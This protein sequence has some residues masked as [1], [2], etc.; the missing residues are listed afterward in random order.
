MP[1]CLRLHPYRILWVDDDPSVTGYLS[2]YL[3]RHGYTVEV[4]ATVADAVR[5]VQGESW[6]LLVLDLRLPDGSGLDCLRPL[7]GHPAR[8]PVLVVTGTG[9]TS[10]ALEAG[11]LGVVAYAE[12]PLHGRALLAAV[13]A[14]LDGAPVQVPTAPTPH[15]AHTSRP[16]A[17]TS[18]WPAGPCA[19][20]M[21]A[22]WLTADSLGATRFLVLADGLRGALRMG[23][24]T[25]DVP[26]VTEGTV[27]PRVDAILTH[28]ERA[29]SRWPMVT[30][31]SVAQAMALHQSTV[32][33]VLQRHLGRDFMTCRRALVVRHG[34]RRLA[35]SGEHVRQ[36]AYQIG[37]EH[38]SHFVRHCQQVVGCSPT[39]FRTL[40]SQ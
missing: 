27:D 7:A 35:G 32:W 10:A 9:S 12:K 37:Y 15:T 17:T 14:A 28:L 8:P 26:F 5:R 22:R 33:R 19:P 20:T 34:L 21:V 11:R 40:L 36:I 3:S 18:P 6:D 30:P 25:V 24:A 31:A 13:R 4:S 1:E 23:D 29:G 16:S 39:G 2:A 38:H